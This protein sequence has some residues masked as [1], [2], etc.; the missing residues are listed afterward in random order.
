MKTFLAIVGAIAILGAIVL[1]GLVAITWYGSVKRAE[2]EG[3]ARM[4]DAYERA[5]MDGGR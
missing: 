3:A 4:R 5:L 2:Y 1:V